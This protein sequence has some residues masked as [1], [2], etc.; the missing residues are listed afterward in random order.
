M[1]LAW[2][3]REGDAPHPPTP[4]LSACDPGVA[5]TG[6]PGRGETPCVSP[7]SRD[8]PDWS[9]ALHPPSEQYRELAS[10]Q[11]K[12][13]QGVQTRPTFPVDASPS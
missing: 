12:R 1:L 4:S 11:C 13:Q 7:G 8:L 5:G 6:R 3:P 10:S 2:Q 9:A